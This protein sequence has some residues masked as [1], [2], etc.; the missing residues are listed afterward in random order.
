MYS[1]IASSRSSKIPETAQG[2]GTPSQYSHNR[3][4]EKIRAADR[5]HRAGKTRRQ[6]TYTE[7]VGIHI[8]MKTCSLFYDRVRARGMFR[9]V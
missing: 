6:Q 9:K 5:T 4:G 1:S 3:H 2:H 8:F 7:R